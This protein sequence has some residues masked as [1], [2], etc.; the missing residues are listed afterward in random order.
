[1]A[2]ARLAG[3]PRVGVDLLVWET[4]PMIDEASGGASTDQPAEGSD[5]APPPGPDSPVT[6]GASAGGGARGH[7]DGAAEPGTAAAQGSQ[8]VPP[9]DPDNPLEEAQAEAARDRTDEQ[10]Y[11]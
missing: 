1:M 10:G 9:P 5:T 8:G 7:G 3:T 6:G 11:Q 4:Y 2:A